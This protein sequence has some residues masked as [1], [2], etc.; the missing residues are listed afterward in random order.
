MT[1]EEYSITEEYPD[2]KKKK[3]NRE[4]E[5]ENRIAYNNSGEKMA[6]NT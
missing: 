6:G 4:N 5:N 1:Y 2:G 3:K